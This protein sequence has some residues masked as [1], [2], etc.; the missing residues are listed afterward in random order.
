M[1]ASTDISA[2]LAGM[3]GPSDVTGEDSTPPQDLDVAAQ[4]VL[5]AMQA[6]DAA[7]LKDALVSFIQLAQGV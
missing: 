6:K 2:I 4:E 7:R 3:P 1:P 5:S